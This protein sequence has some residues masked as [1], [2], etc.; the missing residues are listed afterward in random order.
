M[1]LLEHILGLPFRGL[2]ARLDTITSLD[3]FFNLLGQALLLLPKDSNNFLSRKAG[4]DISI[5]LLSGVPNPL[6]DHIDLLGN[7]HKGSGRVIKTNATCK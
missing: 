7:L 3:S 5:H 4:L 1:Q 2:Q 6:L